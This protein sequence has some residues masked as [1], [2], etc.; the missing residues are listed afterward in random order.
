MIVKSESDGILSWIA[1]ILLHLDY[2]ILLAFS[3]RFIHQNLSEKILANYTILA[4]ILTVILTLTITYLY[5]LLNTLI[6]RKIPILHLIMNALISFVMAIVVLLFIINISSG[7]VSNDLNW[8]Q[9]LDYLYDVFRITKIN[10]LNKALLW[11]FY[12]I[13]LSSLTAFITLMRKR[14]L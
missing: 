11:T 4:Y 10:W 12:L 5:F 9:Y 1:L 8:S 7:V 14:T 13:T 3:G 2:V 6:F